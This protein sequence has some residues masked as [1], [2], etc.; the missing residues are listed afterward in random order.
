MLDW[1][2]YTPVVGARVPDVDPSSLTASLVSLGAIASL[3]LVR[4]VSSSSFIS[5]SPANARFFILHSPR[6]ILEG[7]SSQEVNV[8]RFLWSWLNFGIGQRLF[9]DS[10]RDIKFGVSADKLFCFRSYL[11][12]LPTTG[13]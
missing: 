7:A 10:F 2:Y 8:L 13:R 5:G 6:Y 12:W 3:G 9:V 1:L 4:V 11:R